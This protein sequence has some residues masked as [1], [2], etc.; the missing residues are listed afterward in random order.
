MKEMGEEEHVSEV[1][2]D[3][4]TIFQPFF[5]SHEKLALITSMNKASLRIPDNNCMVSCYTIGSAYV[6]K[7]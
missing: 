7:G 3:R 4:E 2:Q 5:Y 1:G 6:I